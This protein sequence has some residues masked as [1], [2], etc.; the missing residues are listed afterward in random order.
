M[1]SKLSLSSSQ[2]LFT[3][4][5]L[6]FFFTLFNGYMQNLVAGYRANAWLVLLVSS[7]S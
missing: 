3:F 7:S 4:F 2:S 1:K 5:F 6:V